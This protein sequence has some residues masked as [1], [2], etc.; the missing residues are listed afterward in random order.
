MRGFDILVVVMA[1]LVVLAV[2]EIL[3]HRRNLRRIPIRIHVNGT[4]G[5]SSVTRLI[6]GGLRAG[7]LVTCAKT[8]GTLARMILPDGREYPVFRPSK[9]NVIEQVRIVS[10]AAAAGAQALVVE[11]MALQPELQ[12]LSESKLIRATHGVITNARPDHLDVMG[13]AD[14]DVAWAL[15]GMVPP[16][17][18]LFTAERKLLPILAGGLPRPGLRAA[19]GRRRRDRRGQRRGAGRLLLHRARRE[20]GAG[21]EGLRPARRGPARPR[22]AAC[23]RPRPTPARSPSTSSTSSA[24]AWSSSTASPPTIPVSTERIWEARPRAPRRARAAHRRLQ[25]PRRPRR[26]L[27]AARPRVREVEPARPPGADGHRHLYL[28][29]RRRGGGPRRQPAGLP[30]GPR[31]GRDLRGHRGPG[32][33]LGADHGHGQHRR[34]GAGAGAL[35]PQPVRAPEEA[36]A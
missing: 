11:C 6:A 3:A 15:C 35:L 36:T 25:L 10:A 16:G 27:A 20:R 7:G 8:T 28:R 19:R 26:P 32:A 1:G 4:R 18:K 13:P 14:S 34:P 29:P 31:G 5:K 30:R 17:G 24:A 12:W 33:A 22:C 23:G 9:P 2:A 21:A